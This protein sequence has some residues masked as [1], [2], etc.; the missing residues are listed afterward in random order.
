MASASLIGALRVTLGLDSA[1]FTRGT[2]KATAEMTAMQKRMSVISTGMK[3]AFAGLAGLGVASGLM[4]VAR[5]AF[6]MGSALTEAA[7]KVGVTVE[8]LQ[9]MRHVATQNG[10]SIETMEGS[11]NKMTKTLGQLQMGN[12]AAATTFTQLGLSAQQMIGLSP[13]ESFIKIAEALGKIE[14]ETVRAALGNQVFGRS[15]A[16]LK[17]LVDLGADG[18]RK[19]VEEKR[20]D[21]IV[22]TA[23]AAKLDELA[24]GWEKLKGR[25]GTATASFIANQAGAQSASEGLDN[26]GKSIARL[27]KDIQSLFS[28]INDVTIKFHEFQLLLATRQRDSS[29]TS[30]IPGVSD[31]A[32]KKINLIEAEIRRKKGVA[33]GFNNRSRKLP[34][35]VKGA[36]GALA[37]TMS[38]LG[39]VDI[40]EVLD[41]AEKK[42]ARADKHIAKPVKDAT[43]KIKEAFE[44]LRDT[45][46]PILDRLFPEIAKLREYK[47]E[48]NSLAQWAKEGKISLDFLRDALIRLRD[49]Y[50][51][52]DGPVAVTT[53]NGDD[54]VEKTIGNV[55]DG[56]ER[57]LP[58]GGKVVETTFEDMATTVERVSGT[59]GNALRDM[60]DSFGGFVNSIKKGDIAGILI[61]L[62]N[63][64]GAVLGAFGKGGSLS[65]LFGN[66]PGGALSF[67]GP[68]YAAGTSFHPGGLAMV[69]ERGRELVNLP[70]G[71]QVIPN[72]KLNDLGGNRALRFVVD[73]SKYFDAYVEEISGAQMA[74]AAPSIAAGGARAAG[75][76][77]AYRQRRRLA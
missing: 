14:D 60:S 72:H 76:Q 48:Q 34:K 2:K 66:N 33:P 65:G 74:Q 39:S 57:E 73:K 54:L 46:E 69:G 17:P 53:D 42:A 9:E 75:Q 25:V 22:S 43:D 26:M 49:E 1:E 77:M 35:P 15:Y 70:R 63:T 20:K 30:W 32:Q 59:I 7:S 45:V 67:K 8:A 29:L 56:M 5:S 10:L 28:W 62:A 41:R 50:F 51:D 16:E 11:L 44:K 6:E 68:A 58:K 61:G 31:D 40:E 64:I 18:I 38:A 12:K 21:G 24:D 4:S 13:S 52:V 47:S 27:V 71:S 23:Q 36:G 55:L 19:A 3:T 37:G